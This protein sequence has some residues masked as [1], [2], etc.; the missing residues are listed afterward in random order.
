MIF[1]GKLTTNQ[2]LKK[3]VLSV[4][5]GGGGG[6]EGV[7]IKPDLNWQRLAKN[8]NLKKMFFFFF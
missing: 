8:P 5:K 2:N 7:V 4:G 1:L 6:G 3:I